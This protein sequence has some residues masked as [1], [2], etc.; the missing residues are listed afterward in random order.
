MLNVAAT[1]N[2]VPTASSGPTTDPPTI[3]PCGPA[4][5]IANM[6]GKG[7]YAAF[8][9]KNVAEI[10]RMS[11]LPWNVMVDPGVAEG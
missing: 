2:T 1:T 4:S 10:E 3:C 7:G 9:G 6:L 8:C 5:D 11:N